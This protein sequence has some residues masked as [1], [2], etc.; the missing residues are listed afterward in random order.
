MCT[1]SHFNFTFPIINWLLLYLRVLQS[2]C[3]SALL[4]MNLQKFRRFD[5]KCCY[6]CPG[7]GIVIINIQ[8]SDGDYKIS[9]LSEEVLWGKFIIIQYFEKG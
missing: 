2:S 5:K 4:M 9:K 6:Y 7:K 8:F 3:K 1:G